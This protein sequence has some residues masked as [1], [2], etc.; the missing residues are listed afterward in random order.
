MSLRIAYI[1]L[2]ILFPLF[3]EAGGLHDSIV[4]LPRVEVRADRIISRE[5]AGMM[6][7]GMD[8]LVLAQKRHMSLSDLLS[9]HSVVFIKSRGRGGLAT[10]SF[11]GTSPSHT[12]LSWNGMPVNDPATG[13]A[14]L[15]LLPVFV[16]DHL[17]LHH[18]N[19]SVANQA[20]GFGGSIRVGNAA[21]WANRHEIV[22]AQGVGSFRSF[23]EYLRAGLGN[24]RMQYRIRAYHVQ[25]ENNYAFINRGVAHWDG[26]ELT[27]PEDTLRHAD[28]RTYGLLQEFYYKPAANQ[29][30]SL[31]WWSQWADRGIPRIISY[32][33]PADAMIN[34][35]EDRDHR[36]VAEYQLF[37]DRGKL[38]LRPA[39]SSKKVLYFLEN[40]LNGADMQAA[41]YSEGRQQSLM[42]HLSY[43]HFFSESFSMDNSLDVMHQ[44]V[45]SKDTVM[46]T[47]Y[48]KDRLLLSY[49]VA[50]RKSLW[51]R[52]NLNLMIRSEWITNEGAYVVPFLGFDYQLFDRQLLVLFANLARNYRMPGLN[53]LYWQP[54]GNPDLLPEDGLSYELGM[55]FIRNIREHSVHADLAVYSSDIS[56]RII[57]IPGSHASWTP[58]NVSR[59]LSRGAEVKVSLNGRLSA[60]NYRLSGGYAY[61]RAINYGDPDVWGG[62]SYGKQLVY[63]PKHSGNFLLHFGWRDLHAGWQYNAY[64]ERFTTSSNDVSRRDWLYPYFMNDISFGKSFEISRFHFSLELKVHNLFNETYHTVLYQPMPG[65]NYMVFATVGF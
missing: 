42:N 59:V 13:M 7:T 18:G 6:L 54:G 50:L 14:D 21:D 20:G 49:A 44:K 23:E 15:S 1:L 8:S 4:E 29:Q 28:Y 3:A 55:R 63:V 30:L 56:N 36:L 52:L 25:S 26:D 11:R 58:M 33:G 41:I 22:Y 17:V 12:L 40:Q 61:T 47:G 60:V 34:R 32:E 65:R 57:W 9:E 27:H 48:E 35:Q 24:E 39:F 37:T 19:A 2:F 62:D 10:A 64:S 31:R 53:D 16:V 5:L 38:L 45:Q 46:K 51:N 43:R